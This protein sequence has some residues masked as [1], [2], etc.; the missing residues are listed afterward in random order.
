[1]FY[2]VINTGTHAEVLRTKS[3]AVA[4]AYIKAANARWRKKGRHSGNFDF[5]TTDTGRAVQEAR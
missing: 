2:K 3:I 4:A 1:M 5:K